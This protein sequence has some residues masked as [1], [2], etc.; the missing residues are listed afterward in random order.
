M[1]KHLPPRSNGI[2][3]FAL[4]LCLPWGLLSLAGCGSTPPAPQPVVTVP[5]GKEPLPEPDPVNF[6]QKCLERYDR[7]GIRGYRLIMEKQER[8]DGTLQPPE[9]IEVCFRARPYSV[10]MHWLQGAG[11]AASALYVAG[12]NEGKML[13]HPSGLAGRLVSVKAVDP[14]GPE[15]RAGGRYPITEFG[16]RKTLQRTL[17]DWRAAKDKGTLRVEYLGVEKVRTVGDRPCYTLRRHQ[18]PDADGV[19]EVTVYLDKE[20]WF[21]VGTVQRGQGDSLIGQY[22]Y[23]DIQLNPTFAPDQ[24]APAALT[25]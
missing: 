23:R 25:R 6:L 2:A 24:F 1:T 21:Q 17:K 9:V 22:L 3:R 10:F 5:A 7:E 18:E 16:L 14:E 19:T 11:R 15:A 12:E 8:L 13:V 4:G 20:T